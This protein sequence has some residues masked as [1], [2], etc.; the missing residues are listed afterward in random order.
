MPKFN[1]GFLNDQVPPTSDTLLF[2]M[3]EDEASQFIAG[4]H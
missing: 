2:A 3:P 4:C 1:F